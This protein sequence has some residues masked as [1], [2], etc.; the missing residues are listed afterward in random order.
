MDAKQT[1][2]TLSTILL[3]FLGGLI[4]IFTSFAVGGFP[5]PSD[6]I[7]QLIWVEL[8]FLII[9]VGIPLFR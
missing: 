4:V 9:L 2:K 5:F 1:W 7:P 8:V 3:V 6:P